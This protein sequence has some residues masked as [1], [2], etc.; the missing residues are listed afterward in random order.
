[1]RQAAL[2]TKVEPADAAES[3]YICGAMNPDRNEGGNP[4][5]PEFMLLHVTPILISWKNLEV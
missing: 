4:A 3:C 5:I 2:I 1:M